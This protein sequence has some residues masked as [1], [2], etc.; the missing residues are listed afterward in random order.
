MARGRTRSVGWVV[1]CAT[2][3]YITRKRTTLECSMRWFA[4]ILTKEHLQSSAGVNLLYCQFVNTYFHEVPLVSSHQVHCFAPQVATWDQISNNTNIPSQ[5][6]KAG[7]DL[8][9]CAQ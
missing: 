2:F 8:V 7:H 4:F 3:E 5:A 9:E 1:R 6:I